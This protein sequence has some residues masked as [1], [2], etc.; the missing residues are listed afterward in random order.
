MAPL[1]IFLVAVFVLPI[2]AFLA[3]AVQEAD[4]PPVLPRTLVALRGWD[5]AAVPGDAA[6]AA[7]VED[8]RAARAADQA[9]G[10]R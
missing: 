7:L 3:R 8:L 2:G 6:F 4:V 1:L 10:A 9:S 5:G